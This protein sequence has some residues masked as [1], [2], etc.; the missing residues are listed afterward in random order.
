VTS[1]SLG[2]LGVSAQH[3]DLQRSSVRIVADIFRGADLLPWRNGQVARLDTEGREREA[4]L[5]RR[6]HPCSRS[7]DQPDQRPGAKA[8]RQAPEHS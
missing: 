5:A 8:E 7:E 1:K 2:V 4:H 6:R 3:P